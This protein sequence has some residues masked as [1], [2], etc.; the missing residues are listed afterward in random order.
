MPLFNVTVDLYR[1]AN[2]SKYFDGSFPFR[3]GIQLNA[4]FRGMKEIDNNDSRRNNYTYSLTS[5]V[6]KLVGGVVAYDVKLR[7]DGTVSFASND[8]RNDRF[9]KEV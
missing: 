1:I 9:I 5:H 6:C 2:T 4:T 8:W 7:D 3:A